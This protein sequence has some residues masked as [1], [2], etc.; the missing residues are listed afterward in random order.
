MVEFALIAPLF[1]MI[2]VGIIQF[3]V[4]LNYWLDM[5]RIANQGARW[6]VVNAW[7]SCPRTSDPDLAGTGANPDCDATETLQNYLKNQRGAE[8]ENLNVR[9]CF[10]SNSGPGGAYQ[11][12]DPVKV[13]IWQKF[14]FMAIVPLPLLDI[15][16]NTTM[17]TEQTPSRYADQGG[18]PC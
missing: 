13:I 1:F 14:R 16:A 7:P 9:V 8:G 17:R 3:G 12:G 10:P 5:Q 18:G 15:S 2:V 4:A 11:L 6:A